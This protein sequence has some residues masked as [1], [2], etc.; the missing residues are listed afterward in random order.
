MTKYD[1]IVIDI[2][3]NPNIWRCE[4]CGEEI[5]QPNQMKL[6]TATNLMTAFQNSHK[7]CQPTI[8][9]ATVR[10]NWQQP[11]TGEKN[12]KN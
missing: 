3:K 4:R 11:N 1:W 8:K 6:K 9:I 7:K 5:E 10:T 2:T 12:G